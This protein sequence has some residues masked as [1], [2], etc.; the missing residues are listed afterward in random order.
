M[1][2]RVQCGFNDNL[3]HPGGMPCPTY[4]S[5]MPYTLRFMIDTRVVGM[6]WIEVPGSRYTLYDDRKKTS[7]CQLE[8]DVQ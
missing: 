5:N 1:F 7:R 4:E 2:E 3:F 6:N 8:F